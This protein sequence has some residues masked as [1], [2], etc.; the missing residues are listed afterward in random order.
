MVVKIDID[1][2]ASPFRIRSERTV[3][4]EGDREERTQDLAKLARDYPAMERRINT[5]ENSRYMDKLLGK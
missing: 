3:T 5:Y 2:F 4:V 1:D